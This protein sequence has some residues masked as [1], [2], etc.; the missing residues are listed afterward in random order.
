[1]Q[2]KT[3]DYLP[4]ISEPIVSVWRANMRIAF[5]QF[6]KIS[7]TNALKNPFG[8]LVTE[9]QLSYLGKQN[10]SESYMSQAK[11]ITDKMFLK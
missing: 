3:L 11:K 10:D 7:P 6:K 2:F 1:M 9:Y 4:N 5:V 8:F